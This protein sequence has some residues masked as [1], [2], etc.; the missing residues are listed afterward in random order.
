MV[1]RTC[2][3]L[4]ARH[5]SSKMTLFWLMSLEHTTAGACKLCNRTVKYIWASRKAPNIVLN[6]LH[7]SSQ[8]NLWAG[9]SNSLVRLCT[10]WVVAPTGSVLAIESGSGKDCNIFLHCKFRYWQ[11]LTVG[12]G[13]LCRHVWIAFRPNKSRVCYRA[14]LSHQNTKWFVL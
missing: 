9:M 2:F 11:P 1:K 7:I 12:I 10:T 6:T 5:C 4:Q 13:V 14:L 3:M 8:S